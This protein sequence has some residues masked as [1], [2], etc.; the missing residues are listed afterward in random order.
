MYERKI[1]LRLNCGLELIAKVLYGKWKIL[2][3][4]NIDQGSKRPS[5]LQRKIPDASRRVLNIQLQELE[6]HGIIEK[7]IY[8]VTPPKVEY[9]FTEFGNSLLPVIKIMG[10]WG[11]VNKEH[12]Q[13]VINKS[14]RAITFEK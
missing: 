13:S 14:E 7:T 3:L 10:H 5:E 2:L 12:L 1:P 8:P 11:E 6:A 9:S 4:W